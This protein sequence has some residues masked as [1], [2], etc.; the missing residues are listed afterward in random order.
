MPSVVS[1][2]VSSFASLRHPL[3]HPLCLPLAQAEAE[4]AD[5]KTAQV[6]LVEAEEEAQRL[7]AELAAI[8]AT[9]GPEPGASSLFGAML[10]L[11][12]M[13]LCLQMLGYP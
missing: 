12:G 10:L 3:R 2:N 4:L 9:L 6:R 7:R 5:N 8:K 1:S 11:C 13:I